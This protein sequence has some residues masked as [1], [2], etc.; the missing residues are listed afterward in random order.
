MPIPWCKCLDCNK[1]FYPRIDGDKTTYQCPYCKSNNTT[2]VR[3]EEPT[4][5]VIQETIPYKN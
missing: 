3:I 1:E 5:D 2:M 4:Y